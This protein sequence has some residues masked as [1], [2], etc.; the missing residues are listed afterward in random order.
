MKKLTFRV[1]MYLMI[2]GTTMI[3]LMTLA[4]FMYLQNMADLTSAIYRGNETLMDSTVI[5]IDQ[6]FEDCLN[7]AEVMSNSTNVERMLQGNNIT[8]RS[9]DTSYLQTATETYNYSDIFV[10]NLEGLVVLSQNSSLIGVDFSDRDYIQGAIN[11]QVTWSD[12]FYSDVIEQN[13]MVLGYPVIENDDLIGVVAIVITQ[14]TINDLV[15]GGVES[16][17]ET[18]NA[19]I[20]NENQVLYS[21][22]M[23][24]DY[25]ENSALVE[26][27]DSDATQ[28]L[29]TAIKNDKIDFKRTDTYQGYL[30]ERVLG[31][32]AVIEFGSQYLG[33]VIEVNEDEVMAQTDTLK[34]NVIL[35]MVAVLLIV[36]TL[37]YI[38]SK[39]F[40]R[41]ITRT[42]R[43]IKDIAE[44]E[45]DLTKR[46][47]IQTNDEFGELA[48]NFNQFVEKLQILISDISDN[49]SSLSASTT[50]IA[51][52][53]DDNSQT[54]EVINAKVALINDGINNNS[55]VI[56]ETNASIE[57]ITNTAEV[58]AEKASSVSQNSQVVLDATKEGARRL[59]AANDSVLE[60]QV[61]SNE[62]SSVMGRLN[63]TSQEIGKIVDVITSVADQTN[64][65]ALNA[66]IEAARAG[67][68]G[69]GFAVVADEVRKLAE[70]SKQSASD[71]TNLVNDIIS[72]IE[73]ANVSVGKEQI[74]VKESVE[75]I[76]KTNSE[77]EEILLKISVVAENVDMISS[78]VKD[79]SKM[80]ADVSKAM[81]DVTESTLESATATNEITANMETQAAAFEEIAASIQA[82][83]S[84]AD[85]LKEETNKFKV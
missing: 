6:Y 4:L 79:Q 15:H 56:E 81:E 7:N 80:T 19:Y 84:M 8:V 16:L 76:D 36:S 1:K 55:S 43:M 44:G 68:H 25:S 52:T 10:T 17:G 77:F 5:R 46:L 70:D 40:V 42:S 47:Q 14:E 21:T 63:G 2:L 24:G 69:K 18:G 67:E 72:E 49:A 73:N 51:V 82:L 58:I 29:A 20:V 12:L 28:K 30:G 74:Q 41:P 75:H 45:G 60:V 71:I 34:R 62:M 78:M 33:M 37:A 61:I 66:A 59:S 13:S 11:G 35:A 54:L 50:E 22:T 48:N 39:I 83:S 26:Q 57:E 31:A 32:N 23:N 3:P 64:L 38:V 9:D 65:L 53:I 85:M 27:V